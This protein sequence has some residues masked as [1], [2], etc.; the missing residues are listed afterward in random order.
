M[1]DNQAGCTVL[2]CL[3]SVI[4]VRKRA[5][6]WERD[7]L[8]APSWWPLNLV[9]EREGW[10]GR[11]RPITSLN[12]QWWVELQRLNH[13]QDCARYASWTHVFSLNKT[14]CLLNYWQVNI[15][16]DG[17]YKLTFCLV[18]IIGDQSIL[19]FVVSI[20]QPPA[21]YFACLSSLRMLRPPI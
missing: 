21:G 20:E 8:G 11:E 1:S 10:R 2:A 18:F 12:H 17:G 9:E 5:R 4:A 7:E 15:P 13:F 14:N 16:N 3:L 6:E 19:C